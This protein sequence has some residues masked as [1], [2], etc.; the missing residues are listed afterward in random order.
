M[1]LMGP[2]MLLTPR[3]VVPLLE[4]VVRWTRVRLRQLGGWTLLGVMATG[5]EIGLLGILYRTWAVPLWLASA[6]AA[7]TFLL[8]RFVIADRWVFGNGRPSPGRLFRYHG[9]SAGAFTISWLVLN[10]SA[11]V[12]AIPNEFIVPSLLGSAAAF[13]W[14]LLTNFLWVWRAAPEDADR[15]ATP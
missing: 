12:L 13:C 1:R 6:V 8:V 9:A 5:L 11:A 7:E 2:S 15:P 14:S 3:S 4:D 10:G